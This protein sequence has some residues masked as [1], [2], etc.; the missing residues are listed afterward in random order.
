MKKELKNNYCQPWK[1]AAFSAILLVSL[2]FVISCACTSASEAKAPSR[3]FDP[4][5]MNLSVGP[6]DDFYHYVNGGWIKSHPVPSNK[7]IYDNSEI[8]DDATYAHLK[9]VI[10]E[11][12]N[13]T[14]PE[15]GSNLQKIATLYRMGMV[16]ATIDKQGIDPLKEEFGLIDNISMPTD[17][18]TVSTRL[19]ELG[20]DPIFHFHPDADA[21]NSK[22]MVA[23]LAQGGLGLPDRDYYFRQDNDSV[24]TR[25]QYLDH[26]T[27]MFELIGDR[28]DNASK[29]ARTILRMET[30]LAN[31]SFTNVDN[32]DAVKT[33]NKMTLAELKTLAPGI[34]WTRFV[35][36]LGRPDIKEIDVMEPSFVRELGI[37]MQSESAADWKTFLRW[38]LISATAPYLGA[39][40]EN[41]SFDFY[42]RTL[43]GQEQMEPRWKRVINRMNQGLGEAIGRLY[44]ERY[45]DP[46]S[47]AKMQEL[48]G[49]LKLAL[50]Y[51]IQN[52]T[53]M[54]NSTKVKALNKLDKTDIKVGY[55]DK[56]RD[57]SGL[58]MRNDSYIRNTLAT[59]SFE[60]YHGDYGIDKIGKPV[61]NN[62][63][64]LY[65]HEVNAGEDPVKNVLFF[66]AGILQSPYFSK[67]ADDAI[68]YGAIGSVIGHEMTH[69][70]DDQGR[71]YDENGNLTDWWTKSDAQRFNESTRALIDEYNKF[72][73]LPGLFING[74]LTLGENIADFGGLTV[75]YQAYKLS[76][77]A[78]PE[79]IDGFTG[80]QRFFLGFAQSW[81]TSIKNE[82]LRTAVQTN[83]H[84]PAMYRVDGVAFNMPEFYKAFPEIKPSDKMYKP[85]EERPVIW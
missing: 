56:W 39:Q 68:N 42:G 45:F 23:I 48:V 75:A 76:Q 51:R 53:W 2:A 67:D 17:V 57:Y 38:N 12:A 18:Q 13:N 7:S 40:S 11:A 64:E 80:D 84:S 46:G 43:N 3:A 14:T 29:N 36:D 50:R 22:V 69:G 31:A 49:N 55:P 63:W 71:K 82:M 9:T 61:D 35:S 1:H 52:L 62:V 65:P 83:V 70:F 5:N 58:V 37:M 79:K 24:K 27:R 32:R 34:N 20:I 73:P 72:E 30:K 59:W 47:K 74:N 10:E 4:A 41:E 60:F 54:E 15:N 28:P 66:P 16:M 25:A 33:Y 21:K 44:V 77:K 85:E 19:L 78:D 8:L 81:R 26:V 6:G